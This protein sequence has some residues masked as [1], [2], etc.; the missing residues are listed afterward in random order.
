MDG[1]MIFVLIFVF[2]V[3]LIGMVMLNV[4]LPI[5]SRG[6]RT[7]EIAEKSAPPPRKM[8]VQSRTDQSVDMG[9]LKGS[10]P[11]I[12]WP[13]TEEAQFRHVLN[14][15]GTGAGKTFY[16][17]NTV[18]LKRIKDRGN[19]L[20][21]YDP[22]RG[23]TSDI[24]S[25]CKYYGRDYI[26][27]PDCG[28]NP[29]AGYGSPEERAI[30]FADLYKQVAVGNQ[31]GGG[32]HYSYLAQR[33]IS[34][35][36]PAF[37]KAYHVPMTLQELSMLCENESFRERLKQDCPPGY[38]LQRL[39]TAFGKW[40]EKD[41]RENLIGIPM[42]IDRLTARPPL[43]RL[44]NLRNAITLQQCIDQKKVIIIRAGNYPGTIG[45]TLGLLFQISLQS[46]VENRDLSKSNHPVFVLIDELPMYLNPNFVSLVTTGREMRLGLFLSFQSLEQL[47]KYQTTI[48]G[49][50]RTWIAH[51]GL[52]AVEAELLAQTIGDTLYREY[53]YN[54]PH[55]IRQGAGGMGESFR[56]DF[57]VRATEIR[58]IPAN[59]VLF[60]GLQLEN[61]RAVDEHRYLIKPS[62]AEYQQALAA[63]PYA[64]SPP[65]VSHY[66]PQHIWV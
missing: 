66:P 34:L 25:L 62:N 3:L 24:V 61:S 28:F 38:E 30:T 33:Y 19:A 31:E 44:L 35:V 56:Y 45:A 21:I 65:N 64:Y 22:K 52:N 10:K 50:V 40:N 12:Q 46:Y 17:Q 4:L 63:C 54:T 59:E 23:M 60:M 15:S 55:D 20:I 42:F 18:M 51:N 29:L 32:I 39:F 27:Y 9:I 16:M 26:I 43:N 6:N 53:S 41:F 49:S 36:V 57:K 5:W 2:L 13:L 7:R 11:P 58:N 47:D 37:E 8:I 1:G 48:T 14:I